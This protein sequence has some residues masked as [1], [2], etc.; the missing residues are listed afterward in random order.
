[1]TNLNILDAATADM[2]RD[3]RD[4]FLN[5]LIG[6]ISIEVATETWTKGVTFASETATRTASA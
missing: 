6:Y 1:M 3:Q 4:A 5:Y 2:T